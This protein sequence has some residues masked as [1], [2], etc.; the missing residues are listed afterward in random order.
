MLDSKQLIDHKNNVI[1]LSNYSS[2]NKP[3]HQDSEEDLWQQKIQEIR[4]FQCHNTTERLEENQLNQLVDIYE[5]YRAV[6]SDEPGKIRN[7]QCSIPVSYTHL[8]TSFDGWFDFILIIDNLHN[9]IISFSAIII[10]ELPVVVTQ[11]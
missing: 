8:V 3:V 11:A 5:K 4:D 7:Y 10:L 1:Y 9:T 6:F 2:N